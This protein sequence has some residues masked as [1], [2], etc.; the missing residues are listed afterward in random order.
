MS[1]LASTRTITLFSSNA[2]LKNAEV[3][4]GNDGGSGY[5]GGNVG[6]NALFNNT[7]TSGI[8]IVN[9]SSIVVQAEKIVGTV[10]SL[11]ESTKTSNG[12]ILF[13]GGQVVSN[14]AFCNIC[15]LVS[16]LASL[17]QTENNIGSARSYLSGAS[18]G[19]NSLYYRGFNGSAGVATTTLI[20]STATLVQAETNLGVYLD[21]PAGVGFGSTALFYGGFDFN[22]GFSNRVTIVNTSIAIAQTETSIGTRRGYYAGAITLTNALFYAGQS[23]GTTSPSWFNTNT[24]TLM[25]STG[26]LVQAET[27]IGTIRASNGGSSI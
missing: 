9:S 18:L 24:V 13:Y 17:V 27:N 11:P 2:T 26:T 25:T 15:T 7:S 21:E 19:I 3:S 10:R 6:A 23:G 14:S 8:V 4:L 22:A 12:N 5:K 20:S 1:S 16:P